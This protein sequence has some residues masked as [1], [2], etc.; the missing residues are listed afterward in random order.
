MLPPQSGEEKKKDAIRIV[1]RSKPLLSLETPLFALVHFL[2]PSDIKEVV[3]RLESPFAAR[4]GPRNAAPGSLIWHGPERL[5]LVEEILLGGD[6]GRRGWRV[7]VRKL[8]IAGLRRGRN[9][10]GHM[11]GSLKVEHGRL[12]ESRLGVSGCGGRRW[13]ASHW[14]GR[15]LVPLRRR[16]LRR[17]LRRRPWLD[18][19]LGRGRR[20]TLAIHDITI[21]ARFPLLPPGSSTR[22]E[23]PSPTQRP[24]LKDLSSRRVSL[25]L[26]PLL[27]S[28]QVVQAFLVPLLLTLTPGTFRLLPGSPVESGDSLSSLFESGHDEGSRGG[29]LVDGLVVCSGGVVAGEV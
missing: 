6:S 19:L 4:A 3:D 23:L 26:Q 10:P 13:G 20:R 1:V 12:R 24:L 15:G 22:T 28:Q 2:D 18:G 27:Q 7:V 17:R 8:D 9:M 25:T 16:L 11:V 5:V 21:R 29:L 14:G